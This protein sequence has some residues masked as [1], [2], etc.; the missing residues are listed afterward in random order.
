MLISCRY[1]SRVAEL[2]SFRLINS[3]HNVLMENMKP[4]SMSQ[5][6]VTPAMYEYGYSVTT[7][8]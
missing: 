1:K 5:H 7:N 4:R 2:Y 3:I 8:M 6:T